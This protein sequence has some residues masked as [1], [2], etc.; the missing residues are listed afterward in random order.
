MTFKKVKF[1]LKHIVQYTNNTLWLRKVHPFIW[2]CNKYDIRVLF[3]DT[4]CTLT[5]ILSLIL[6]GYG[7]VGVGRSAGTMEWVYEMCVGKNGCRDL[8]KVSSQ[9]YC[10]TLLDWACL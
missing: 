10:L 5:I 2:L 3:P 9:T 4:G 7:C 1:I 8:A 6:K